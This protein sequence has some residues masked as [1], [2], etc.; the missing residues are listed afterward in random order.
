MNIDRTEF[1]LWMERIMT[2][3][4]HFGYSGLICASDFGVLVK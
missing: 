2:R 4:D 1:F 3:F